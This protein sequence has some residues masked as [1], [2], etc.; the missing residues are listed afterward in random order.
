MLL[1]MIAIPRTIPPGATPAEIIEPDETIVPPLSCTCTPLRAALKPGMPA[2]LIAWAIRAATVSAES[3]TS[4]LMGMLPPAV[5][6]VLPTA[7]KMP[8]ASKSVNEPMFAPLKFIR[9]LSYETVTPAPTN[10]SMVR[11]KSR[12]LAASDIGMRM[13][14]IVT[15]GEP[16]TPRPTPVTST[17]TVADALT[18]E[19]L[20]EFATDATTPKPGEL[21]MAVASELANCDCV[22][23]AANCTRMFPAPL[24]TL[25]LSN[26][27]M[28]S[29]PL[30]LRMR[31]VD[32][33][34]N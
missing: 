7:V 27:K 6:P 21:V 1:P 26:S 19:I 5:P 23:D 10:W 17:G 33:S 18:S 3:L 15:P 31:T 28:R 32:P 2:A 12:K 11:T 20:F 13:L 4:T 29:I 8:A 30:K 24:I 22:L 16:V 9:P 25:L 14:P 34:A